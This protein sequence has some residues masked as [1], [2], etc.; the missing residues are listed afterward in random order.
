MADNL[1]TEADKQEAFSR[2]YASAVAAAAGYVT[3]VPAVDRDSIDI[4]F[5]AGGEAR[6][7]LDAQLKATINLT[8]S[9]D[10]YSFPLKKKNYED[11]R[12]DTMVPRILIV[13]RM[14][15]EA[16]DWIKI[17]IEELIL[18]HAAYW[19]NLN[20]SPPTKNEESVTVYL[21]AA[22]VFDVEGLQKLMQMAK[23]GKVS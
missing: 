12:I 21:P 4:T 3:S 19:V 15:Q 9:G 2:V 11:L 16:N 23:T 20:G 18:R 8:P 14:P 22:N 7:K 1:L 5:Q 13:L 6:P 10:S 17:S